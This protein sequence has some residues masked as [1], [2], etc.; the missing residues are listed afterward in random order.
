MS[1]RLINRSLINRMPKNTHKMYE[2]KDGKIERK[3]P[4]CSRCGKGYFMADH[5]DRIS[6]GYCGFSLP[7]TRQK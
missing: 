3:T 7:K 5:G 1:L 4:F 6:C 2:I